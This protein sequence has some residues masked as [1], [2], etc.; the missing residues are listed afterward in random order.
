MNN[1]KSDSIFGLILSLHCIAKS[2]AART[3]AKLHYQQNICEDSEFLISQMP[4]GENDI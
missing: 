1:K 4:I 2:D 3:Q